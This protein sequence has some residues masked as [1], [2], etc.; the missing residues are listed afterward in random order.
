MKRRVVTLIALAALLAAPAAF[1][2][3]DT[4]WV[5]VHATENSSNTNVELHLRLNLVLTVL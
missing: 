4:R 1:A 2:A 3:D 5:N